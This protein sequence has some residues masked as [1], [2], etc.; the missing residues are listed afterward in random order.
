MLSYTHAHVAS[1][2][3]LRWILG[4]ASEDERVASVGQTYIPRLASMTPAEVQS[5]IAALK[6]T[7]SESVY[8][9]LSGTSKSPPPS[10]ADFP[11]ENMKAVASALLKSGQ[12]V[13]SV[14]VEVLRA[15]EAAKTLLESR[16]KISALAGALSKL[17]DLVDM[18]QLIESCADQGSIEEAIQLL[19][20]AKANHAV[21]PVPWL[22]ETEQRVEAAVLRMAE[23]SASQTT[24]SAMRIVSALRR[25]GRER[26]FVDARIKALRKKLVRMK[27]IGGD[28]EAF[29]RRDVADFLG[30]VTLLFG[31]DWTACER[32]STWL[33]VEVLPGYLDETERGDTLEKYGA[34]VSDVVETRFALKEHPSSQA[35]TVKD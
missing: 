17:Q 23:F 28:T 11:S 15:S 22:R 8:A 25:L 34:S 3:L 1:P 4:S 27:L 20:F 10:R 9:A 14:K 2:D 5:E 16:P 6:E 13:E 35:P 29:M 21:W 32:V 24:A 30:Q 33:L 26:D 31:S 18:P 12:A 19:E 7:I